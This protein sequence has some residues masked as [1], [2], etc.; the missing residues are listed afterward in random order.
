MWEAQRWLSQLQVYTTKLDGLGR[1]VLETWDTAEGT[2]WDPKGS[3]VSVRDQI[4]SSQKETRRSG[5]LRGGTE[6]DT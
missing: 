2:A 4:P 5:S 3:P 6:E 1:R